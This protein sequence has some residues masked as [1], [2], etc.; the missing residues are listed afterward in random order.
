MS[1]EIME[2]PLVTLTE[3]HSFS[4]FEQG[5]IIYMQSEH[6]GS[7]LKGLTNPYAE[8]THEFDDWKRGEFRAML[9]VQDGEE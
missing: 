4:P 6:D 9:N 7:P 5:Y 2:K 3:Y 1:V 8:G